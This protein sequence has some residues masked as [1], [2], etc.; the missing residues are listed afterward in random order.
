MISRNVRIILVLIACVGIDCR[1]A[2]AE[3]DKTLAWLSPLLLVK[4]DIP[5]TYCHGEFN[6]IT[7]NSGNGNETYHITIAALGPDPIPAAGSRTTD[8][9]TLQASAYGIDIFYAFTFQ[10]NGRKIHGQVLFTQGATTYTW[11]EWGEQGSCPT[12]EVATNG[13]TPFIGNDFV[14]LATDIQDISLFRSA[15]GHDYSDEFESCRSMKHYYSPPVVKRVNDTVPIFAP[16]NG[17]IVHLE[18]EEENFVDD[19]TTNQRVIIRPDDQP[20]ILIVLF[21]V[22]LAMPPLAVGTKVAAGQ[23]IGYGRLVRNS[24]PPSHNFDIALHAATKTGIRYISYFE[25]MTDTLFA[26]YA[27]WGG[28]TADRDNFIIAAAVR[29]ADPLTCSGQTFTTFGSLSSW[30]YNLP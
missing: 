26:A 1:L 27:A 10:D 2:L 22:D 21:H 25:A 7:I 8:T 17:R 5:I 29:D 19:G 15:A 23:Q 28:G 4:P 16:V 30:Y 6:T 24:G 11:N 13:V 9:L 12:A 3:E 18:T 14:N 20:A